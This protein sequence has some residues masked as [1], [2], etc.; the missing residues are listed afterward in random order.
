LVKAEA[1]YVAAPV[2]VP[3]ERLVKRADLLRLAAWLLSVGAIIGFIFFYGHI[4]GVW[5]GFPKGWDA[6]NHLTRAKYWLD[7]FP[8][9]GWQYHWGGGML[10]YRTYGPLLHILV[11]LTVEL[12]GVSPEGSLGALGFLSLV[13]VGIGIF[14]YVKVTTD[15]FLA[16]VAASFLALSAPRLWDSIIEGGVYPRFFAFGLLLVAFWL[17]A[18]LVKLISASPDR[19]Y[20][21][22]HVA[23]MGILFSVLLSHLLIAF[24]AWVGVGL[25]IWF[26]GWSFQQ[27]ISTG[28]RIF[29]PVLGLSAFY[30]LPVLAGALFGGSFESQ[31]G[32]PLIGTMKGETNPAPLA[33]IYK[34]EELGPLIVP[35][36]LLALVAAWWAKPERK[37]LLLP[38][39]FAAYFTVY[40]F[41]GYLNI[42]P[43]LHQFTGLIPYSALAFMVP[44]LAITVGVVLG[45]LWGKGR[46]AKVLVAALSVV[47]IAAG[48]GLVPATHAKLVSDDKLHTRVHDASRA[49][50]P[51]KA[52]K[53]LFVFEPQADFQHR[54]ATNAAAQAVW[55]NYVYQIPQERDYYSLGVLYPDWRAWFEQSV[56]NQQDFSLEESKMALDWFAAKWFA[57]EDLPL[58]DMASRYLQDPDFELVASN[59]Q[60]HQFKLV[61]PTPILQATNTET[62]LAIGAPVSHEIFIRSL[63]V[64]NYNSQKAIPLAGKEF[65]DSYSLEELE[66]FDALFLYS[67]QYRDKEKAFELLSSYVEGGGRLFWETHGSPDE[68]GELPAPAPVSRVGKGALDAS[69]DIDPESVIGQDIDVED[70]NATSYEGGPWGISAAKQ[71]DLRGWA[72]PIL[73]QEGQVLLAG[74]EY[75][76]GRVVWSGFNFPYHM[77]YGQKNLEEAALFQ[78][79]LQWLFGDESRAAPSYQAEFVNPEKRV[80]TLDSGA[81]GVLFKESYF[82]QWKARF[83]TKEGTQSLPIY[84]AGPGMMY[85]PLDGDS[86][87]RVIFEYKRAWYETAGWVITILSGL[88]IL[89]YALLLASHNR[90]RSS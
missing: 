86:S 26:A 71:D 60:L 62:V 30:I 17:A 42:P 80:V 64:S 51:E 5:G 74:G 63:S 48:L 44:F 22:L 33:S 24:F 75:G 66:R 55:F 15:N 59:G 84:Q 58:E 47:I 37:F 12:F 36:F 61:S 69:W 90:R 20:R 68:V 29:V 28:L 9:V 67:Y 27:R 89:G 65:V 72:R 76:Q 1:A 87:G 53:E 8:N 38:L 25:M 43:K 39:I 18:W 77:T 13:L 57:V 32:G 73:E 49:D 50:A 54:F 85:V 52:S 79:A 6:Y 2:G 88:A 45:R 56:W 16:A 4:F 40:A 21:L 10:F 78:Q 46:S 14:G 83:V 31:F 11:A 23:L 41:G 35:A 82:P 7:F 34:L 81:N 70:F 3:A 19:P